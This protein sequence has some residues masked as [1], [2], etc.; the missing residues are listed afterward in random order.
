MRRQFFP[1]LVPA[2]K[3]SGLGR[4][5]EVGATLLSRSERPSGLERPTAPLCA[6]APHGLGRARVLLVGVSVD[7]RHVYEARVGIR[8]AIRASGCAT[9]Q[10]EGR[11]QGREVRGVCYRL[12]LR[13]VFGAHPN[14]PAACCGRREWSEWSVEYVAPKFPLASMSPSGACME[15]LPPTEQEDDP[16]ARERQD[17]PLDA[18]S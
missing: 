3:G 17:H 14:E 11:G 12:S 10:P 4:L 1:T 8:T 13:V 5:Q 6:V 16:T 2:S 9:N 18:V 7:P 15:R